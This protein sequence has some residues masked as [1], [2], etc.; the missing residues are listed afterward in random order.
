M[1]TSEE[2]N[3]ASSIDNKESKNN[4]FQLEG[5]ILNSDELAWVLVDYISHEDA[6]YNGLEKLF[7]KWFLHTAIR[8][9]VELMV[10][11]QFRT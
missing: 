6:P 11:V 10:L 5:I 9:R 8:E 2:V 3:N 4:F 7:K 1:V